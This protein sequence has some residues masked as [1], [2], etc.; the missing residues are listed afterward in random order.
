MAN[1]SQTTMATGIGLAS[2]L[3]SS[4]LDSVLYVP[5]SPSTAPVAAP[6]PIAPVPPPTPVQ[7]STAP[8]LLTYYRRPRPAYGPADSRPA[9]D[10]AN[11]A[12]LSPLSQPIALRKVGVEE[13]Y[14]AKRYSF[15]TIV[16]YWV[17]VHVLGALSCPRKEL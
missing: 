17:A 13:A 12:D 11:T 6:P 7:P 10:R 16:A 4:P 14:P 15:L 2:P 5:A 3:P 9:P 1:G 8:P